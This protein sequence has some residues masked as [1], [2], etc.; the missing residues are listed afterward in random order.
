MRILRTLLGAFQVQLDYLAALASA[1]EGLTQQ[2]TREW[3]ETTLTARG[4]TTAGYDPEALVR[5][6]LNQETMTLDPD[7]RYRISIWGQRVV[8]A[9]NLP[10]LFVAAKAV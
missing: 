7:G 5:W 1:P 6:L 2:A 10:G 3:F 8:A 4:I 9:S